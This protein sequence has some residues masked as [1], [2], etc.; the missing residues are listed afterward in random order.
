M[1]KH[2]F[3]STDG[4]IYHSEISQYRRL[5]NALKLNYPTWEQKCFGKFTPFSSSVQVGQQSINNNTIIIKNDNNNNNTLDK[6]SYVIIA[7]KEASRLYA[8]LLPRADDMT[9]TLLDD[10][11]THLPGKSHPKSC[12][13]VVLMSSA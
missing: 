2:I 6:I 5:T 13:R 10:M 11:Q 3:L 7:K 4:L 8:E 9:C 1:R 12:S